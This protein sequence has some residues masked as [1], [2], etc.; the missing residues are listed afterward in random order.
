MNFISLLEAE[1]QD[2]SFQQ[3]GATAC[4][5]H[6]TTQMFSEFFGGQIISQNLWPL[7]PWTYSHWI[8]V[9]AGF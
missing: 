3:G 2:C 7:N 9:S 8:S 4:K 6:S 5:A 1:K